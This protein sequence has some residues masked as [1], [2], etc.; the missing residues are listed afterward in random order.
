MKMVFA[1]GGTG[2]HIFP[3]VS[4][5]EEIKKRDPRVEIAYVCGKK[6][7]ESAILDPAA[8]GKVFF[9][10]SAPVVGMGWARGLFSTGAFFRSMGEAGRV[11]KRERPGVVVGF[12]GYV[13]FPVVLAARLFRIP[14]LIHEQ[15]VVP[16]LANRFLSRWVSGAALSFEETQ[17]YLPRIREVRITGNPIRSAIEE[18]YRE[19]ALEFFG[20]SQGKT[21]V[22]V[23]GGSQGSQSI[24]AV[25]LKA[26]GILP[27]ALR[28]RLQVLH[29]C[30]RAAPQEPE[31]I[32]RRLGIAGRA[33]SFFQSMELAYSAADFA[34][35]RAGATFLAEIGAKGLPAILVPY[36]YG[37][38]HQYANAEVHRR[39]HGACVVEQKELTGERLA[40]LLEETVGRI[41]KDKGR[42]KGRKDQARVLL[43]DFI[44]EAARGRLA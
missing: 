43:A 44:F 13:S 16:G 12:G 27:E 35:G 2:G 10:S 36:P 7:V 22:L 11:L 4:V 19:K 21:T 26:L 29:L 30:G 18:D 32:F 9:V 24:N 38:R 14:T 33:F 20:F 34:I 39:R 15:N 25:F 31:E 23:L 42:G 40:G 6:D 1:C 5:A 17:G 28:R 8:C 41:G 3:A 37:N